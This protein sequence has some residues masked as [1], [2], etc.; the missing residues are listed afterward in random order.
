[1]SAY[2]ESLKSALRLMQDGIGAERYLVCWRG[3]NQQLE[4]VDSVGLDQNALFVS[5]ALS[6]SLL[7]QV[8]SSGEPCWSDQQK[9]IDGSLTFLL[10][11]IKS[12]MCVP[13]RFPGRSETAVLYVDDRK[14]VARFTYT[15][16][17]NLL[18]LARRVGNPTANQ[19]FPAQTRA[20]PTRPVEMKS[21]NVF[22]LPN[23]QQVS[24]FRS[25]STFINA[26]IPLLHGIHALAQNA[27]SK[28]LQSFCEA[29]HRI[30][31]KGSPLSEGCRRLGNFSPMVLHMLKSAENAGQLAEVLGLLALYLE[32]NY[33]RLA[34]IRSA[35]V[36]PALVLIASL[37]MAIVLPTFV[38]RD[39]L[40]S[41][42]TMAELPFPTKI[43]VLVGDIARFPGSWLAGLIG[44]F[45]LPRLLR[46][47]MAD[48]RVRRRYHRLFWLF[49]P[50]ARSYC[51]WQEVSL[52]SSLGLQLKSGVSLLEALRTSLLVS[53]SPLLLDASEDILEKVRNGQQL[54]KALELAP[55]I[56]KPFRQLLVAGEESGHIVSS[57][58]W[59]AN[60]AKLD[61][62][63]AVDTSIRLVEPMAM[64]L[65]GLIVG[66]VTLGT[67]LPS[68]KLM[69]QF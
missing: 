69:D 38:L 45:L 46:K 1:M 65:M 31:L 24:F 56:S 13:V 22:R 62:D 55:G 63:H 59:I 67:L 21:E 39:Q 17:T 66:V 10:A 6:V 8:A 19:K 34:R 27:E 15:D 43:L 14:T 61:F 64:L 42:T 41:Y 12:Y 36:Y 2:P 25:L 49:G 37:A 23:A 35:L 51:A 60:A 32:E 3:L 58:E 47:L 4:V 33:A 50:T 18:N 40:K 16:Y 48:E 7:E 11:G 53:G 5:E 28:V 29:L 68:L 30:L 57:L 9:L 20:M 44:V 52:A 54:S 26:G